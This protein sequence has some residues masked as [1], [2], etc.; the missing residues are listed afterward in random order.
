MNPFARDL[1]AEI[2]M[3]KS[4]KVAPPGQ[5]GYPFE[6]YDHNLG[7][8]TEVD[9]NPRARA[10]RKILNIAG[11]R[12]WGSEIT[13]A[14]DR[15]NVSSPSE[16]PDVAVFDLLARLERYEDAALCGCDLPDDLPAR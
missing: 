1:I 8:I 12:G 11:R 3:D 4:D 16:L 9:Q 6:W 13:C 14:C 10:L 5:P 15:E 7:A 2:L